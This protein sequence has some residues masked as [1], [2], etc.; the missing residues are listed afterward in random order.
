MTTQPINH[1][2]PQASVALANELSKEVAKTKKPIQ[3]L[4]QDTQK[5]LG[6]EISFLKEKHLKRYCDKHGLQAKNTEV[7][8][9]QATGLTDCHLHTKGHSTFITLGKKHG[10]PD[11][12]NSGLLSAEYEEGVQEYALSAEQFGVDEISVVR[13]NQIHA[14]YANKGH[15]LTALGVVSPRIRHAK[16]SFDVVDCVYV[17]DKKVR[18]AS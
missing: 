14:F 2:A 7:V 9:M 18:L 17:G 12:G 4:F 8:L 11:P 3:T 10:F 1:S 5:L 15:T 13:P 16:N 6:F